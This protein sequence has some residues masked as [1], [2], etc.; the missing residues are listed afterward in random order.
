MNDAGGRKNIQPQ[1]GEQDIREKRN[2]FLGGGKIPTC[3][4]RRRTKKN[5][6]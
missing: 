6:S 1:K 2:P 4:K 5:V 3:Q